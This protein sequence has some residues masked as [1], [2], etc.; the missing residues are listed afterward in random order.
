MD[1]TENRHS[2]NMVGIPWWE[3]YV[4]KQTVHVILRVQLSWHE[5]YSHCPAI[6]AVNQSPGLSAWQMGTAVIHQRTLASFINFFTWVL[7][8]GRANTGE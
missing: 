6:T 3:I 7:S 1:L 5:V 4:T 8:H 2:I